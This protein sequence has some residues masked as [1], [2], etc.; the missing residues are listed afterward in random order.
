MYI[1]TQNGIEGYMNKI[2]ILEHFISADECRK[3]VSYFDKVSFP[4]PDPLVK[5]VSLAN[6]TVLFDMKPD[7]EFP[8]FSVDIHNLLNR[9]RDEVSS[10]YYLD[11]E[12]KSSNYVNMTKGSSLGMHVD[13]EASNDPLD[14]NDTLYA[15]EF[16]FAALL[17]L[18]DDY[19][20]GH[21]HFPEQEFKESP[22]PGTLVFFN[23]NKDMPHE[24]T[25]VLKGNRKNIASFYRRKK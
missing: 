20:G 13:M 10:T 18:N 23:G 25:E 6:E 17:Y 15:S 21:L 24:V 16:E 19:E 4:G 5:F 22:K 9:I 12:I 1:R 8:I 7:N 3:L 2:H 14:D 11:L